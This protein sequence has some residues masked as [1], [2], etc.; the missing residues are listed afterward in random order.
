M[1]TL[2]AFIAINLDDALRGELDR[3]LRRLRGEP[4]SGFVRWVMPDSVHLTLKFLGDMDSVRTPHVLHAMQTACA[5][6]PHF[7]LTVRGAGCFP[8]FQRPNVIW[9][10]LIGQVQAATQL[11]QRIESECAVLGFDPEERPFSPHLTL[12]RVKRETAMTERNQVGEMVRRLDIGQLGVM[13]ADVVHLM[14]SELRPGGAVY[15]S[16]GSVKLV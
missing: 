4:I 6:M 9:A 12:G 11:A 7:D 15:S 1:A 14:R 2:R 13:H 10:G 5:D 8:N 3:V 16:L